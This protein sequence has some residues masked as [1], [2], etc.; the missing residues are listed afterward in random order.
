VKSAIKQLSFENSRHLQGAEGWLGLGDFVSASNELEEI[1]AQERAHPAVLSLRYAIYAK[2]GRRDMA[3][4]VAE[5][6]LAML[7]DKARTWI[8]L[9]CATR[10]KTGGGIPDAK[11][12]LNNQSK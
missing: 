2:G 3:A 12:I 5:G 7:P 8:N 6:L 10:R 4:D 1:M 11:R 9:T